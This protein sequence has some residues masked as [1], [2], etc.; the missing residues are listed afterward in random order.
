MKL[1]LLLEQ[2]RLEAET[3][4]DPGITPK[5]KIPEIAPKRA[6]IARGV[7]KGITLESLWERVWNSEVA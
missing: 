7:D 3:R 2:N 5:V 1:A 4:G 6:L